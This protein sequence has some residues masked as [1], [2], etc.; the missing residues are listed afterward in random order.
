MLAKK[1][2]IF[3]LLCLI[4]SG[5]TSETKEEITFS[6]WGSVTE[7]KI[8]NEIIKNFE[9]ENP[10]IKVNFEH[11]PQNYF[12]KLHLFFASQ[13]PPDV[14]FINNLY[15]PLYAEYLDDVEDLINP[16]EYYEESLKS[17]TYNGKLLAIPR[18]ISN[19][20]FYRNKE[21]TT[22]T[23]QNLD[24]FLTIISSIKPFGTSYEREVYFML[25]YITTFGEDIYSASKSIDFYKN[26]EGCYAPTPAQTGSSTQAQLFID[27][28][29]ALY[30]SGRWMYPMIK[31]KAKFSW[32]VITF[33]GIVPLDASGWAIAKNSKHKNSAQK[34]VRFLASK[35]NIRYFN[36]TGLIVPARIDIS[37]EIDNK[38]FLDAI[39]KSK[40][41]K[42]DKDYKKRIDRMNKEL[43]N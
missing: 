12:Q 11:I 8:I 13:K 2:I 28:K 5:C 40:A 43:F 15:L 32:D 30:L 38:V 35:E 33:P 17:L 42:I 4:L 22:N 39:E 29:I 18:D 26:L 41:L 9:A 31:E 1:C 20:L 6:S 16:N 36:T 27:G 21:L 34:F 14:I 19:L 3:L 25:P 10:E 37:K 23:P 24:E 7:V